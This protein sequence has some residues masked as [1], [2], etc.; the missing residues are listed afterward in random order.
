VYVD[1]FTGYVD[2][3]RGKV[4]LLLRTRGNS[5]KMA[6]GRLNFNR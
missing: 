5:S 3:G 2:M 4:G 1:H 6:T